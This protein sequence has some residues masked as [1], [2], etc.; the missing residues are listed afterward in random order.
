MGQVTG[1][2]GT[3]VLWSVLVG[4][5]L[6]LT[7]A[8][9][10]PTDEQTWMTELGAP[11]GFPPAPEFRYPSDN[12]RTP[13][14]G[15][16]TQ[17]YSTV[18]TAVINPRTWDKPY[19]G[20]MYFDS[21]SRFMFVRFPGLAD[22]VTNRLHQG[23]ALDTVTLE[24]PWKS[25]DLAA[26]TAVDGIYTYQYWLLGSANTPVKD[27]PQ[28]HAVASVLRRP[29][30]ADATLGPTW[31]AFIKGA[32]YWRAGGALDP[33]Y[34]RFS[35][36]FGPAELS[37]LHT[38]GRMD[39]TPAL[40][41]PAFGASLGVRLRSLEENGFVIRKLQKYDTK[42]PYQWEDW[43]MGTGAHLIFVAAP[44]LVLTF[45]STGAPPAVVLAP[46]VNIPA[47]ASNL[48]AT[49]TGGQPTVLVPTNW[50][51]LALHH[52]PTQPAG[53][54][55]WMWSRIL[56]VRTNA[57]SDDFR[58]MSDWF[59]SGDATQYTNAIQWVMGR[60]PHMCTHHNWPDFHLYL[61]EYGDLL[62]KN[63][64]YTLEEYWHGWYLPQDSREFAERF[65][66]YMH[67]YWKYMGTQNMA[68]NSR[69]VTTLMGEYFNDADLMARGAYGLELHSREMLY[70]S[71]SSQEHGD[72]YYAAISLSSLQQVSRYGADPL[73]KLKAGLMAEKFLYEFEAAYHPVTHQCVMPVSRSTD[74]IFMT[75]HLSYQAMHMLSRKGVLL[76]LGEPM[77]RG[78]MLLSNNSSSVRKH[79]MLAPWGDDWESDVIDDK[80]LPQ[81]IVTT[82][83]QWFERA[84][85]PV[86]D[87]HFL[88]HYYGLASE[89][90]AT[91][92]YPV[93]GSW[94]RVPRAVTT[95]DE[96]GGLNLFCDNAKAVFAQQAGTLLFLANPKPGATGLVS[97]AVL[98][99][100]GF[101]TSRVVRI[102]GSAAALPAA[103][104]CGDRI[105]V[106]EGASYIGL[107]P[108]PVAGLA[109]TNGPATV[110]VTYAASNLTVQSSGGKPAAA[111]WTNLVSGFVLWMA[112]V[113]E[114]PTVQSFET[115]LAGVSNTV[116]VL[117][118]ASRVY[119]GSQ[120]GSNLLEMTLD[121][122]QADKPLSPFL[123]SL[124]VNGTNPYP[125]GIDFDSPW[126]QMGRGGLLA[127][128]GAVLQT[129]P[130]Q[131]ALLKIDP[132]AGV[133][134]AINPFIDP[135]DFE[136]TTP[137]GIVV[138]ADGQLGLARVTVEAPAG[139]VRVDY[140]VPPAKGDVGAEW[141]QDEVR[142]GVTAQ[143]FA[144]NTRQLDWFYRPGIDVRN[145][146]R[147]SARFL[148]V[149][150]MASPPTLTLNGGGTTGP[151][152]TVQQD[153]NTWW[154]LRIAED[155]Q[156]GSLLK[157]R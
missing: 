1:R 33:Q 125:A 148:L 115:A 71:G 12:A 44:E 99:A 100:T 20:Q 116:R 57:P 69:C 67:Y 60:T 30:T 117:P 84:T 91:R 123:L 59:E 118:G 62:P 110:S 149:R 38:R 53:M 77:V 61:A 43:N 120:V 51:A 155:A 139:R 95:V 83:H 131:M 90:L 141:L 81:T 9:D 14:T 109:V 16:V 97:R 137:E 111:D 63:A 8:A 157:I 145:A 15:S 156:S 104:A 28:W 34:D 24:L 25:N 31:N 39:V 49:G 82:D 42:Y 94:S 92:T 56:E 89:N 27:P 70:E 129:T 47:L 29:W 5:A 85:D 143:G 101:E 107:I 106:N 134:R 105:V 23:Y 18:Q 136:L 48:T 7:S 126:A 40:T 32:G 138:K 86:H 119:A 76:H 124:T 10:Y 72:T 93:V 152:A 41:D 17:R 144:Y 35:T 6:A 122:S 79:A 64:R 88:G 3:I 78:Y 55:D 50:V 58:T 80:P 130:G 154:R 127:K 13:S 108:L 87:T 128:G 142:R 11:G 68:G 36:E 133:Y 65:Y 96:R 37:Y 46:P 121:P 66:H 52:R 74:N 45:V 146:H 4:A 54:S 153:G 103:A 22:T 150:G 98:F 2:L 114:Y 75:Q 102:N 21:F 132:V 19:P 113:S 140:A 147:D 151:F 73:R 135:V 26:A 112:D